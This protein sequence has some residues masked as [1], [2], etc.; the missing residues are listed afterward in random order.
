VFRDQEV[1]H[2]NV[3]LPMERVFS[4]VVST[5]VD[6]EPC[7]AVAGY[8]K[9]AGV[10][11]RHAVTLG[12]V[13]SL[14]YKGGVYC[15]DVN[16]NGTKLFFGTQSGWICWGDIGFDGDSLISLGHVGEWDLS[17]GDLIEHKVH[18]GPVFR[19]AL[20]G[21]RIVTCDNN[22]GGDI[23]LFSLSTCLSVLLF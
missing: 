8:G 17:S 19:M 14:S 18:D 3:Q 15:V 9:G 4:N 1:I 21:D 2:S 7:I 23:R 22:R 11:I 16:I 10:Y 5:Y 20:S 12:E 6:G 13:R